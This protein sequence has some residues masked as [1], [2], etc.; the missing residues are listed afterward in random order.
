MDPLYIIVDA[1]KFMT[2]KTV[3]LLLSQGTVGKDWAGFLNSH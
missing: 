2:V 3:V 1:L